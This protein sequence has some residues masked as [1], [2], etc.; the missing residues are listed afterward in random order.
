MNS[1]ITR[2]GFWSAL[3]LIGLFAI[4]LLFIGLPEPDDFMASEIVGH[5]F[6]LV[7]LIFVFLGM[8]QY[9]EANGGAFSYWKAVK[10]GLLIT[11]FP[12]VAFGLYNLLYVEVLDPDFMT[13]YAEYTIEQR[14]IG[15]SADEITK[16][17]QAVT[18]E[19]KMF[20]NSLIKFLVMFLS[21]F[22]MGA[23]V[24]LVS[25]FFV[26]KIEAA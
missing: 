4:P 11:I 2:N 20:D 16:I 21:V 10:V 17:R 18:E 7:S 26:K 5:L 3:L 14:G 1:T 24:S 12:A 8:K 23:I 25:A 15:K 13:K 22:V 9:R 19:V 6:I